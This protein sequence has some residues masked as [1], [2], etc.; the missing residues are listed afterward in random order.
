MRNAFAY[1]V[2]DQTDNSMIKIIEELLNLAAR[3]RRENSIESD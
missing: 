3:L 1:T 2:N